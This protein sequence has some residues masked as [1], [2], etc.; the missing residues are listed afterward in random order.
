MPQ[1]R[2]NLVVGCTVLSHRP[3]FLQAIHL[4]SFYFILFSLNA[5]K[6]VLKDNSLCALL[7]KM[8]DDEMR[9]V[10]VVMTVAVVSIVV[11]VMRMVA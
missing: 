11:V 7:S 6:V 1:L 4:S 8:S 5:I 2:R 9:M 3:C 10:M